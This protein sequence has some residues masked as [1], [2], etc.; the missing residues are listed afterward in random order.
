MSAAAAPSRKI[1]VKLK[2]ETKPPACE[3]IRQDLTNGPGEQS[4]VM[5]MQHFADPLAAK[6]IDVIIDEII[7]DLSNASISRSHKRSRVDAIDEA[8]G[9][10]IVKQEEEE[11]TSIK[12]NNAKKR[13]LAETPIPF[14]ITEETVNAQ[15]PFFDYE[16]AP[17]EVRVILKDVVEEELQREHD[18]REEVRQVR[19]Q[20]QPLQPPALERVRM[21]YCAD[22]LR[23]AIGESERPCKYGDRCVVRLMALAFPDTLSNSIQKEGFTCREW[24][25]PSELNRTKEQRGWFPPAPKPCLMD[26]R[27]RVHYHVLQAL[28]NHVAP[29]EML[30]DHESVIEKDGY[31]TNDCFSPVS[32]DGIWLGF[33]RPYKKF[34]FNNVR[35]ERMERDGKKIPCLVE[36]NLGPAKAK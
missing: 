32:G 28:K 23:P 5:Y 6:P 19:L 31:N 16:L 17:K 30:P 11:P 2:V 13:I 27:L 21:V 3:L 33:N 22:F 20:V 29:K 12:E 26:T 15:E 35:Y 10:V 34:N 25:L 7:R 14:D 1:S 18:Y 9:D 4:L 8:L 24:L 36:I